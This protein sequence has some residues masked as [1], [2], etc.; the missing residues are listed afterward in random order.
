MAKAEYRSSIRSKK[1]IISALADLLQ[2]KPLDKI[3]VT[4]V[5]N[6]AQINRGTFYAHFADV[7]DVIHHLI[8]G[9]F[10][11]IR[12]ALTDEYRDLKQIPHV[13]LQRIQQYLEEDME[14]CH[15]VMNSG[16]AQMMQEELVRLVMDY[17]LQHESVYGFGDHRL[18]ELSIRFCAG[19]LV[20]LYMDWFAGKLDLTLDQLTL[21]AEKMVQRI[22]DSI[23]REI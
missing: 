9:V 16:A 12:Q 4:D 3:T 8:L 6:R 1:L 7:P 14:F 20:N 19:G 11:T 23:V 22:I 10:T 13:L 18:Y 15:K 5:V 2:Q 17:M 21:E